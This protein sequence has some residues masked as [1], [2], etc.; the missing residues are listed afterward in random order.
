MAEY[1]GAPGKKKYRL[2]IAKSRLALFSSLL[3]NGYFYL[4][5]NLK[6]VRASIR[7]FNPR[8]LTGYRVHPGE[9]NL[10]SAK[11]SPCC[12]LRIC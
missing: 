7:H 4:T 2:I 9:M 1:D 11:G 8:S 6:V 5:A 10:D 3:T 12:N